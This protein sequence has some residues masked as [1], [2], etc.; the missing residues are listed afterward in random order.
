MQLNNVKP[1]RWAEFV[2]SVYGS[3]YYP[4]LDG[5]FRTPK[6]FHRLDFKDVADNWNKS[7]FMMKDGGI[8]SEIGMY[9]HWP[10][11]PSQ[12]TFCR[13]NM[14]VPK[15]NQSMQLA[16]DALKNEMNM[17]R[18][19]FKD[20]VFSSFYMGGGTPTFMTNEMLDDFF[21][22]LYRCFRF[23]KGAQ[24]YMESSPATLTE[25]KVRLL[26][27]HGLNRI[28]LGVQT[29]NNQ[30]LSNLERTGQTRSSVIE[31][32]NLLSQFSNLVLD[33]DLM[34]GLE[35]QTPAIFFRDL[36]QVLKLRPKCFHLYPFDD[37]FPTIFRQTGKKID[38]KQRRVIDCV[39]QVADRLL[40][41]SGYVRWS[42]GWED[43]NLYPWETRQETA[44][45]RFR[46][47]MLGI[48]YGALSHSFGS[49]WY[50][51][52]GIPSG[53]VMSAD[54]PDFLSITSS[55]EEEMRGYLIESLARSKKSSRIVFKKIFGRDI[56]DMDFLVRPV[57]RLVDEGLLA[58]DSE[59]I[60]W[61]GADVVELVVQLK[62]FYSPKIVKSILQSHVN[63]FGRFLRQIVGKNDLRET[64]MME[65]EGRRV[66]AYYDSRVWKN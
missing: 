30:L 53:G 39:T 64:V 51:H 24:I 10:F 17:L 20:T 56:M 61:L 28:T 8:P 3:R 19:L 43:V 23:A 31:V 29:F 55:I 57:L 6:Y 11:C 45:R 66:L 33:I 63:E 48:G 34:V 26:L 36:M 21:S 15:N 22:H 18:E 40:Y 46:V 49:S 7:F 35:D 16:L 54:V 32:F 52:P 41:K 37:A 60:T 14:T 47:S 2:S 65:Q 5:S 62:S 50:C 1:L 9:V 12:C 59:F 13:C 27:K 44:L 4:P 25:S 38:L 42:D 58:V